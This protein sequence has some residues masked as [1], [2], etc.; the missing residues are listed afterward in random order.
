VIVDYFFKVYVIKTLVDIAKSK[1][2]ESLILNNKGSN[3]IFYIPG[4]VRHVIH[5]E[6]VCIRI[7]RS[8]SSYYYYSYLL[9]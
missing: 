5:V 7:D 9:N 1:L 8:C 3:I 2:I 6:L 4:L